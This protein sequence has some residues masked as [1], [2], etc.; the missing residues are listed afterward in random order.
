MSAPHPACWPWPTLMVQ[1][2]TSDA[3]KSTV[4]A[5]LCRLLARRGLRVAPFKPQNMA[6]NSAVTADGGEIG[7]A[8]AL[9]A[10][11]AGVEP[12][13]DMNPVLLKPSSDTGAQVI[14][15]GRVR[16]DMD[17][18]DYHHYKTTAMHAVL[19]SYRRL[20]QGYDAVVVEGAGSPAEINLRDRDI[21]NMGFAEAVD[22]PVI[23]VADIDK[24]GV[25]AH[26]TG[27]LDCL[28]QSERDRVIGFVI[29]RFRGDISLLQGGLD[30]LEAKTGKPVLAV[31][32]YLHGLQLDAEDSI[33][34]QQQRGSFDIVVPVLPRISNHTDFDALRAHPQVNLHFVG[35]DAPKPP[36]DLVILPGSKHTRADLAFLQQQGWPQYL[37]RHLRYGG[38]LL[39][40]CGGYQMLGRQVHDPL[41][42]EGSAGSSAGLGLLAIDTTLAADKTLR[43]RHG[44]CA[45][46]QAAVSGYEI[47]MG[48]SHG[49]DCARPAFLLDGAADGAI[50]SD[51]Q[52]MGSYLH[53][54]FDHP[55]AGAALLQWA[56][57]D[58]ADSV[59]LA[60]LR[61]ASIERL[62]DACD[63]LYQRLSSL[64]PGRHSGGQ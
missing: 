54:L 63:G 29:N 62:A 41:G 60:A 39:G 22:C 61:E 59:D 11:A 47:H 46:A 33:Q 56:G 27:T 51:G 38:K 30:W 50:S 32:P 42:V 7:R 40:I 14:I 4:V 52:V 24:G 53:G 8:Q 31:L 12:H 58:N 28:S 3:G 23:I 48:L 9:Q 43:Q 37:Q 15:Q 5:A 34:Q 25:F 21:A 20:Q 55:A 44:Q 17:A 2:C 64:S 16:A 49:P 19:D 26:L 57:L 36:A 10:L 45:F 1:G 35:P 18:R 13:S 6:L